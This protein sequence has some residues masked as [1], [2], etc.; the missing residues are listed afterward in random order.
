MSIGKL[1]SIIKHIS[2]Y[3]ICVC[4]RIVVSNTYCVVFCFLF[5]FTSCVL[6]VASFSGLFCFFNWSFDI[7]LH[8]FT[9]IYMSNHNTGCTKGIVNSVVDNCLVL[10]HFGSL[11][12]AIIEEQNRWWSLSKGIFSRNINYIYPLW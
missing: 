2:R 8:L 7:P 9:N 10:V 4:L 6:Y 12:K 1:K 11:A 5:F 3:I